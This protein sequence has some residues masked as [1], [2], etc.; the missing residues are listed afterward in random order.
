MPMS[1]DASSHLQ[2][3]PGRRS[4]LRL[5]GGSALAAAGLAAVP[6]VRLLA[7]QAQ[8]FIVGPKVPDVAPQQVSQRV[9]LI[10]ARDG[11]PTAANQ[12]LMANIVFV[13]T[14]QGVVMLDSGCSL[15]IGEMAIRMI[16]TVTDRPVVAVF[17]SHYHGDHWLGNHAFVNAF[18]RDLPIHALAHTREQIASTE[19]S[20]WR[21]MMERWT[22]GATLGTQVVVPNRTV[23]HAQ[24][25]DFGDVQLRL[26]HYGTAHTPSDLCVEVV[27][28]RVTYVGDVAMGNRIANMDDGSYVGT[29]KYYEALQKAA[30]D[31]TWLP[32]HGLPSKSLLK[33]YGDF[34][35]GIYEPCVQAVKA[36][37]PMDAART[38]VL[39]DPRVASRAATMQG[40]ENNIGKYISLAYL[41]AEKEAF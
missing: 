37:A 20:A 16:R 19:G 32:G 38:A 10:H 24:R 28:D 18:G 1:P 17:N 7:Q 34:M 35:A 13:V 29:L 25:F 2:A 36:G 26:H 33:D 6:E 22:Q 3:Q 12:G 31:Q 9:W 27:Q 21:S 8:D 40:F 41:E 39:R 11:F 30:G 14:K 5:A 4:F 15:Q 23:E